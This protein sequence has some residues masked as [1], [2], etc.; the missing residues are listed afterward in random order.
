VT[1]FFSSYII[2]FLTYNNNYIVDIGIVTAGRIHSG[3][4]R[5]DMGVSFAPNNLHPKVKTLRI[6]IIS[7]CKI[8]NTSNKPDKTQTLLNYFTFQYF[9]IE[10]PY[11]GYS[12]NAS[13]A[14]NFISTFMLLTQV[15]V[16]QNKHN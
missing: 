15:Q 11:E 7:M 16:D 8:R 9:D 3:Y 2:L 4:I 10:L 13:F 1:F 14:L 12:R 5:P 6:N